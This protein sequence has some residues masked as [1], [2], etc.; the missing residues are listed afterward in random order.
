MQKQFKEVHICGAA[1]D[2]NPCNHVQRNTCRFKHYK[3]CATCI[4]ILSLE[5]SLLTVDGKYEGSSHPKY[6]SLRR[7]KLVLHLAAH[8]AFILAQNGK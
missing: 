5:V 8:S 4:G 6:N 3:Q 1:M 2:G 7:K